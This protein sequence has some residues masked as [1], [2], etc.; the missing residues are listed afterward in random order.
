M[1][2]STVKSDQVSGFDS[3]PVTLEPGS[4]S[5]AAKRV[6]VATIEVATTSIDEAG[7]IIKVVRIPSK[8]RVTSV[9]M[10]NDDLD[11]DGTPALVVD[12]GL[13]NSATG[14]A[15]DADCYSD[16]SGNSDTTLQS[17]NKAGVEMATKTMDIANIG[18]T[19][20]EQANLSADPGVPL[21][22]AITVSTAAATAATGTVTIVVEGTLDS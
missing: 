2:A 19:A 11:S 9:K 15:V 1:T 8:L 16:G 10:F 21:D 17:A 20:W 3:V 14:A 4:K 18:K 13:Y 7:D 5:G 22:V 6:Y 12:V